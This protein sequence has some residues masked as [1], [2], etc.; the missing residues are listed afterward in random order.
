MENPP[1]SVE[2]NRLIHRKK[3]PHSADVADPASPNCA[4]KGRK[5]AD[6][7]CGHSLSIHQ[8]ILE[9]GGPFAVKIRLAWKAFSCLPPLRIIRGF[10]NGSWGQPYRLR[11]KILSLQEESTRSPDWRKGHDRLARIRQ[12][13]KGRLARSDK[14]K[15]GS[16]ECAD[17][18]SGL[19]L[20]I[21]PPN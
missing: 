17:N 4:K 7:S 11:G 16:D 5:Q 19:P 15:K 12:I 9:D 14:G 20:D 1:C 21:S 6:R 10:G 2:N 13:D 3:S 8:R 18:S